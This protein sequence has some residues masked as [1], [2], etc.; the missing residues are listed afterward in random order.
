V[1]IVS[2]MIFMLLSMFGFL[3]SPTESELIT[4]NDSFSSPLLDFWVVNNNPEATPI[5]LFNYFIGKVRLF[6]GPLF[7]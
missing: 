2:L 1:K 5:Y 7:E 6:A 3:S 4:S